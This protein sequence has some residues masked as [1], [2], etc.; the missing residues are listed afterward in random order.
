MKRPL[1]QSPKKQALLAISL[2]IVLLIT[3]WLHTRSYTISLDDARVASNIISISSKKPGW[4]V[5]LPVSTG[6]RVTEASTLIKIDSRGDVLE[7]EAY[8]LQIANQQLSIERAEAQRNIIAQQ[9]KSKHTAEK[10]NLTRLQATKDKAESI[11]EIA[12]SNYDRSSSMWKRKLISAESWDVSKLNFSKATHAFSEAESS[13][14]EQES[15]LLSAKADLQA[16]QVQE[17]T[18]SIL[19]QELK[20]LHVKRM[21]QQLNLDDSHIKSPI[22][23]AVIDKKFAHIGEY[24]IPGYRLMMLHDPKDIW[25][26]ANAKETD[27]ARIKV[28]AKAAV[29]IDAYPDREFTAVVERV[30]NAT[31]SQFALLPNPNPSGNFTKVTQRVT[32]RL[33]IEQEDDLLKPG[34]MAEV[35]I[36]TRS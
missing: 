19:R 10:A 23:N 24:V 20:R 11:L 1:K 13:L 29:F 2:F 25:I 30:D 35:N 18:L 26:S 7:L 22:K 17:K 9:T 14:I 28:G 4:I 15:K 21:N 31:T 12:K 32:I 3:D 5:E 8:D 6:D 27:V 34:M 36:D 16:L 33:A